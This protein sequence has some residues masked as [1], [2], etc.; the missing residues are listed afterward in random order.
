[1]K[2]SRITIT[3]GVCITSILTCFSVNAQIM[4]KQFNYK[5]AY[6]VAKDTLWLGQS[7]WKEA[8]LM[9][10][11]DNPLYNI[12]NTEEAQIFDFVI[13]PYYKI[14]NR[15]RNYKLEENITEVIQLDTTAFWAYI[16]LQNRVVGYINVFFKNN[17]WHG[18]PIEAFED[19]TP[20]KIAYEQV[21]KL[22]PSYIFTIKYLSGLWCMDGNRVKVYS[23]YS[24][25][26]T[27]VSDYIKNTSSVEAIR[28]YAKGLEGGVPE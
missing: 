22:Q 28:N 18:V 8:K 27:D 2:H 12:C 1:M 10:D 3:L 13:I 15:G 7:I 24:K 5:H 14:S 26:I 20:M 11:G 19:N 23:F 9:G 4:Q 17:N 21:I 16:T 25:N 6:S